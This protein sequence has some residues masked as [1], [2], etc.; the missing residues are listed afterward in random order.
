MKL[1]SVR[2][3]LGSGSRR[4]DNSFM[5]EA[6]VF[7]AE[8]SYGK[9]TKSFVVT[10]DGPFPQHIIEDLGH[11]NYAS[12]EA[13]RLRVEVFNNDLWRGTPPTKTE[14]A[15]LKQSLTEIKEGK[16][17]VYWQYSPNAIE[18]GN[19]VITTIADFLEPR[20][21]TAARLLREKRSE[22]DFI[23]L[24]ELEAAYRLAEPT[25]P[26]QAKR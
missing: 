7:S 12:Q 18:P 21:E 22:R 9:G 24:K 13:T 10:V 25:L 16:H 26:P 3:D 1:V 17:E 11:S 20:I 15:F 6:L 5:R 14:A 2:M 4:S 23:S 19:E 8:G